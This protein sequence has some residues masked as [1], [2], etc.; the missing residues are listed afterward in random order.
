MENFKLVVWVTSDCTLKCRYCSQ[1]YT[2]EYHKEY[3]MTQSEVDYI[4]SSCKRRGI[5]FSR[6][7]LTGGEP[8][9]WENLE[10]GVER[11]KE[12]TDNIFLVTNGNNP[13]RI[14]DLKLNDFIVS[15]SQASSLQL[16]KYQ[17]VKGIS[18]NAHQHK[19]LPVEPYLDSLPANCCVRL[20]HHG[21]LK[22]KL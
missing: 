13:D 1:K 19:K 17:N 14:I 22:N 11:F 20:S 9:L 4:V 2:M 12:L 16:A 8:S 5:R 21:V 18:Y 3:Q 10:Y 7:E 6:V 15:S